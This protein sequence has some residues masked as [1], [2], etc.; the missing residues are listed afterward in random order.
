MKALMVGGY[1]D[2]CVLDV[3]EATST[4]EGLVPPRFRLADVHLG[5]MHPP[6]HVRY[7]RRTITLWDVEIPVYV[8]AGWP[9]ERIEAT[10][11]ARLLSP[12]AHE[13]AADA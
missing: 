2:G 11:A 6:T 10:L 7:E 8:M 5:T 13:L 12:L 3:T 1:Q 4:I 9:E